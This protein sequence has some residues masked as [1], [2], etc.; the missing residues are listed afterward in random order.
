MRDAVEV[1]VIYVY[2][3]A[4]YARNNFLPTRT[5]IHMHIIPAHRPALSSVDQSA[6][7]H[8]ASALAEWR[9]QHGSSMRASNRK[10]E[11]GSAQSSSA[12]TE[13]NRGIASSDVALIRSSIVRST[14]GEAVGISDGGPAR[15]R[16]EGP[17]SLKATMQAK[18]E[19]DELTS[20]LRT[21]SGACLK[22]DN[23]GSPDPKSFN[24]PLTA[25]A[26][27]M[28]PRTWA[29][30][31]T[32]AGSIDVQ[33]TDTNLPNLS[34]GWSRRRSG[35][36]GRGHRAALEEETRIGMA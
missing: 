32:S 23:I 28:T 20:M 25:P 22:V 27:T 8:Q 31:A 19:G 5:L 18:R 13:L 7:S 34:L 21:G 15:L 14:E 36:D 16:A 29:Q 2:I 35:E 30:R 10:G 9:D 1:L 33:K 26:A 4:E 12:G 3:V 24:S 17:E 11:E 6:P